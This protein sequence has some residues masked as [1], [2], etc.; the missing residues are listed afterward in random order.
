MTVGGEVAIK[1]RPLHHLRMGY[2]CRAWSLGTRNTMTFFFLDVGALLCG[3]LHHEGSFP[4]TS[5]YH[6]SLAYCPPALPPPF[7]ALI[8]LAQLLNEAA[9]NADRWC[10]VTQRHGRRFIGSN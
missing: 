1:P 2:R 4:V 6:E 9:R 10:F 5:G 7:G 3:N 8:S